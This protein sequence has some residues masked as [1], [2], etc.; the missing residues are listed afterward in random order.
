MIREGNQG[1]IDIEV[2]VLPNG[3][4][5]DA[6]VVKSTGFEELDLAALAEAKRNWRLLP[7][8]R[9]G[10]A[11]RAVASAA[12]DLQAESAVRPGLLRRRGGRRRM[13]GGR[14]PV[15]HSR[16]PKKML[17]AATGT[18]I[19]GHWI[20]SSPA[21]SSCS[22]HRIDSRI[23]CDSRE[24]CKWLFESSISRPGCCW[25]WAWA[26]CCWRPTLPGARSS[27]LDTRAP[28][29]RWLAITKSATATT[30]RYRP[31]VRF[32][33]ATGEIVTVDGQLATT[34]KRFAIGAQVPMVYKWRD[35]MQ[36]RVAL[37]VDNWLG[38][39]IAAVVGLVGLAGGFLVRRSVRRE[40]AK[41]AA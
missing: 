4:V 5:G 14:K 18:R 33:T 29:A 7:A 37:F 20:L 6:R 17:N 27:S 13:L 9:D 28:P 36:A 38:P 8:T 11:D 24:S 2:Y 41:T 1:T 21:R 22:P 12:R 3:R 23:Y 31:R 40:L 35:P 32:E 30:T 26:A 10:V 15:W 34:S 16:K 19:H 39:G 25:R